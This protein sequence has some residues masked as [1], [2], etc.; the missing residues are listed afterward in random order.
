MT[1]AVEGN[2]KQADIAKLGKYEIVGELGR[3]A[4]GVV[5]KG[6]DP[7]IER[8]VAI[9]TVRKDL[10][11]GEADAEMQIARFRRE[12]QAAGR[13]NHPN[14]V[15]VYEYGEDGETTYIAMEFVRG[16]SLKD[17]FDADER[18]PIPQVVAIMTAL[19]EALDYSHR[20]GIVH[21]DI[22]PAN[23]MLTDDGEVKIA[24]FGIARLESSSLTQAGTVLGTP[25]Y[26]SPEQF[27][28]QT[29]DARSD[30][31]S[32]GAVFYQLLTGEKPFTGQLTTIMHKVLNSQP[33]PPSVLNVQ[34]PGG[35]DAVVAKAMAKRPE[36]RF[37]TAQEFADAIRAVVEGLAASATAAPAAA[38]DAGEATLAD[39]TLAV[40]AAGPAAAGTAPALGAPKTGG[41]RLG[42]GLG[43]GGAVVLAAGIGVWVF[44]GQE[45]AV[46]PGGTP[47]AEDRGAAV[48][49]APAPPGESH[50]AAEAPAPVAEAT[51]ALP[52]A[53]SPRPVPAQVE[54]AGPAEPHPEAA[55]EPVAGR[56]VED[57]SE[58]VMQ[59]VVPPA[60]DA[61]VSALP[62]EGAPDPTRPTG[63]F[64]V[65]RIDSQ[66]AG[67]VVQLANGAF[68]G[69][70]PNDFKLAPGAYDLVF[71]KDGYYDV[72]TTVE[73]EADSEIEFDVEFVAVE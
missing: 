12:A 10:L 49:G 16:R 55:G 24:D 17:Y 72:E 30:I 47:V 40:G 42:L 22:K 1:A 61:Q 11:A 27:M 2:V 45:A 8:D 28:G 33:E 34:C 60:S 31:F 52:A 50:A 39:A 70:T 7:G 18:F 36:Q 35:F 32:A 48:P 15:A 21:R 62:P 68:L 26:M 67:A 14:I 4:M 6:F 69:V 73:V 65:L 56:A 51:A 19:L 9:K 23:I 41:R 64:G 43:L 38:A 59:V 3:G 71:K 13:L 37:Q 29:V 25:S 54:V 44:S 20:R 66:P 5:Y 63:P 53:G 46:D 58:A 57:A